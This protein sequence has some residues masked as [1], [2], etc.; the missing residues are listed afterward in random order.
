M[1]SQLHSEFQYSSRISISF[2]RG[3]AVGI[4]TGYGLDNREV[5]VR[6]SVEPRIFTSAFDFDQY[7][8]RNKL[9]TPWAVRELK[10]TMSPTGIGK[11]NRCAG[12]GRQ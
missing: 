12:E 8:K 10:E 3:S 2:S 11:K 4:A 9:M 6:V 5:G 1:Y 7:W